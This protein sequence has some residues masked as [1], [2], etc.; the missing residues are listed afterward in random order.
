M[1]VKAGKAGGIEAVVEAMKAHIGND[2]VCLN[3]CWALK[4]IVLNNGKN[5][6]NNK[7]ETKHSSNNN[8]TAENKIKAKEAEGIEIV[9]RA[10]KA[11]IGNAVLCEKG[12]WALNGIVFDNGKNAF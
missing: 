3:G 5:I 6:L 2:G 10:V 9:V 12:C 11:H 4:N 1:R 7:S 8:L